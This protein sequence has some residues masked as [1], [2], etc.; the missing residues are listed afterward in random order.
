[1]DIYSFT[2]GG[3]INLH[4][5]EITA[6]D[7]SKHA[8]GHKENE[9]LRLLLRS[10]PEVVNKHTIVEEVW[11]R[12]S[13][14]ES[15]VSVAIAKLRKQLRTISESDVEII[16][17]KGL[18]YRIVLS[19]DVLVSTFDQA[20]PSK[21]NSLIE[22]HTVEISSEGNPA[23]AARSVQEELLTDEEKSCLR[24]MQS[25]AEE[26]DE[27]A[28]DLEPES[29]GTSHKKLWLTVALC[30]LFIALSGYLSWAYQFTECKTLALQGESSNG[31]HVCWSEMLEKDAMALVESEVLT[32]ILDDV[33]VVLIDKNKDIKLYSAEGE[34]V[35]NE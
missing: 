9:L 27:D 12:P 34:R 15:A 8:L 13:V 30:S 2:S 32:R 23:S 10:S 18:G 16:T 28:F 31:V 21:E 35:V 1:M 5:A 20:I 19:A 22:D 14:S 3:I 24:E 26:S 33:E 17:A 7:G 29:T 11:K 6:A 25:Y 4:K